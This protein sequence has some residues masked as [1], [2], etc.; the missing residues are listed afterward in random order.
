[1]LVLYFNLYK[2]QLPALTQFNLFWGVK[3][4]TTGLKVQ[5][6]VIKKNSSSTDYILSELL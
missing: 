3:T 6:F 4:Y 5:S 1:M 2:L